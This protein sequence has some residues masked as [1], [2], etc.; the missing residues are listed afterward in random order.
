MNSE[1]GEY[2]SLHLL[3]PTNETNLPVN[4]KLPCYLIRYVY[5][6]GLFIL[7]ELLKKKPSQ[8]KITG[9]E[10]ASYRNYQESGG[11]QPLQKQ[12]EY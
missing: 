4:S 5:R 11:Y 3:T 2:F 9:R 6:N 7:Q 12:Q 10:F 8:A 1:M